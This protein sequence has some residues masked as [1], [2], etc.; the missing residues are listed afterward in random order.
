M[1]LPTSVVSLPMF[2]T[3]FYSDISGG[4]TLEQRQHTTLPLSLVD[5]HSISTH[6]FAELNQ[7]QL[8]SGIPTSTDIERNSD[9][10]KALHSTGPLK[11]FP[12]ISSILESPPLKSHTPQSGS[13]SGKRPER[14]SGTLGHHPR[15]GH[16]NAVASTKRIAEEESGKRQLTLTFGGHRLYS[17]YSTRNTHERGKRAVTPSHSL[18]PSHFDLCSLPN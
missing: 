9:A 5:A 6:A 8:N 13:R 16:Q 10:G 14:L 15:Q 17:N 7:K 4:M 12:R 11:L 18:R 3:S 1:P 2:Y